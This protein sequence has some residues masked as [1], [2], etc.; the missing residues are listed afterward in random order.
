M[1]TGGSIVEKNLA[2][3]VYRQLRTEIIRGVLRPNA[4]LVEVELAERLRVS[5]TPVRESLQRL[6]T[7][8]LIVSR[9][10]RWMVYEHSLS[11]IA[12][13]YEVRA[14][15][16][17]YGARLAATRGNPKQFRAI[18]E[19]RP[20]ATAITTERIDRVS[21]NERFHDLITVAANNSRLTDQLQRNRLY[22]FNHNVALTYS[23]EER[24]ES[25]NQ[26]GQIIDAVLSGQ[27]SEAEQFAREHVE[28]SLK[29]ILD[30]ARMNRL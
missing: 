15:L 3:D 13:I 7:D 17:G 29:L 2:D 5:R 16:E 25:A 4:P 12:E 24:A 20:E 11:E 10:R 22:S 18:A 23:D 9:R 26:H 19:S 14:A 8:G 1:S 21:T 28:F 30:H 27:A 6:A